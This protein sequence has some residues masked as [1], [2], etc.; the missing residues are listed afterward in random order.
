MN[1]PVNLKKR[2]SVD[3]A[4]IIE[5]PLKEQYGYFKI[6]DNKDNFILYLKDADINSNM[7]FGII[8]ETSD[9]NGHY[10][11]YSCRPFSRA[12]KENATASTTIEK[13]VP[14]LNSWLG[15]IKFYEENSILNDPLLRGYQEEFYSD[16]KINEYNA[17]FEGFNYNQQLLLDSFLETIM[18][19]IDTLKDTKNKELIEEIKNDAKS[20][21]ESITTET[22]NGFMKR[23]SFLLAKA[24]KGSIKVCNFIL[25][26][27]AKEFIKGG[28]KLMFNY[29]LK[30]ADKLPEYI[31]HITET[32]KQINT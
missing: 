17:D 1:K 19:D 10:I 5:K 28:A 12:K 25:K 16:F 30:N 13:F 32:I 7:Y 23:F 4:L 26:E 31:H 11:H 27:F 2:L 18:I 9:S 29:A 22:K 6:Q 20:L 3:L 15:S 21:Q 8:K 24:R 14:L